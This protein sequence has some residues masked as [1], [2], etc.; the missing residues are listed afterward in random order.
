MSTTVRDALIVAGGR[1]TRLQPLTFGHPKPLLSF[2]G[3]PFLDGVIARLAAAGIER[4]WLVVGAETGPFEDFAATVTGMDM[5]IVDEPEPLDTA[6]GVRSVAGALD[7]TSLVLNGD[8]LTDVDFGQIIE[9]HVT[10]GADATLVLTRVEDT[11]SF[12]VCVRDGSRI[13]DFVEKPAPGTLPGQDAINAGTYVLEPGLFEQFPQG[14]L[15]F[16][17]DVFPGVL[18]AGGHVEGVAWDGVWS[19]LGTPERWLEGTRLALSGELA[20][21]SLSGLDRRDDGVLAAGDAVIDATAALQGPTAVAGGSVAADAVIGP[22]TMIDPGVHVGRGAVVRDS[23]VMARTRVG[24]G[25]TL[26]RVIVGT[27][28]VIEPGARIGVDVVIGHGEHVPA[29]DEVS[30]G[31]RRPPRTD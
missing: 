11:S 12:G 30:N 13:V 6:G 10:S 5:R 16:E 7:G 27:D 8:I 28:A 26:E 17:R 22:N 14:S 15:S 9:H 21:P 24:D 1:G 23:V 19:D 31:T 3:R 18:A 25:V 4:T 20:W 29:G 2:C